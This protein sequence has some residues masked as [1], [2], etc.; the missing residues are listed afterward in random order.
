MKTRHRTDFIFTYVVCNIVLYSYKHDGIFGCNLKFKTE[1][2]K[3]L[4][5]LLYTFSEVAIKIYIYY[6]CCNYLSFIVVEFL[7]AVMAFL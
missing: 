1:K 5:S 7:P 6:D 4:I 2:N 3:L